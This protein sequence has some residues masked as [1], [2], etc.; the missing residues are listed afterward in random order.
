MLSDSGSVD[1]D[2]RR[3]NGVLAAGDWRRAT[4]MCVV[5]FSGEEGIEE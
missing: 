2:K 3:R 4:A 1:P 5:G